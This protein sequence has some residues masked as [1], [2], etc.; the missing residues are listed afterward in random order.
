MR[1]LLSLLGT[2]LLS[3]RLCALELPENGRIVFIGD[4]LTYQCIYSA[5]VETY[6]KLCAGYRNLA[7]RQF[8]VPGNVSLSIAKR[9]S[10]IA[11]WNPSAALLQC[12]MNDGFYGRY[13]DWM[14]S[15]YMDGLNTVIDIL[16]R[17]NCAVFLGTPTVMDPDYGKPDSVYAEKCDAATYN[18]TLE[19]LS[20]FTEK[21]ARDKAVP[22]AEMFQLMRKIMAQCK[23]KY[24]KSFQLA[25][26]DGI[27]PGE[28]GHLV[29]TYAFLKAM[30][31]DGQIADIRMGEDGSFVS[32]GH[33]IISEKAF[34]IA[35]ESTR[36]PFCVGPEQEK[37]LCF[38]PFQE[39]FNRF[40]LTVTGLSPGK[41]RVHWNGFSRDFSAGEL[42]HGI[43]LAD[44]FRE[45]PF[46]ESFRR[47]YNQIRT[48]QKYEALLVFELFPALALLPKQETA[49]RMKKEL[50]KH[51]DQ[52]E[53]DIRDN[54]RP[55]KHRIRIE[56]TEYKSQGKE[57][58]K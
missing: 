33:K 3:F 54:I 48:R 19:K 52:L 26:G 2:A 20:E 11:D 41:W 40:R 29:M 15:N 18:R 7:A 6:L 10:D 21:I 24:G 50:L 1:V 55:L 45:N 47:I 58:W 32:A 5:Q 51:R 36:F 9:M 28:N 8:G 17:R 44:A 31:L 14:G 46:S 39:E 27:H 22:K 57:K 13:T 23:E 56:K 30:R 16:K 42:A 53:A 4:S 34:D 38:L 12:G 49:A 37:V 43:N 25:G 35:L